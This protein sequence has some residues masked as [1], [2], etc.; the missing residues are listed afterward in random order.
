LGVDG[1]VTALRGARAEA[2]RRGLGSRVLFVQADLDWPCLAPATFDLIVVVR[3]LAR[4]L[5]PTLEALLRPGGTLL[6]ATY[7]HK[8][9]ASHPDFNPTF[10]LAPGELPT[11]FPRLTI[12]EAEEPDE[13]A[14]LRA[15]RRAT[16]SAR[17]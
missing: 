15:Q 12:L 8:R 14:Y 9:L 11:L 7:T 5:A 4:G 13:W 2:Q 10:L 16:S 6:Y 1:S 3:F 17:F